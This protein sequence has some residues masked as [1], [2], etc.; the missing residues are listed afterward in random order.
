MLVVNGATHKSF[1]APKEQ[2][3]QLMSFSLIR[4]TALR[5]THR[6]TDM[7][8]LSLRSIMILVEKGR[9]DMR[10]QV[11]LGQVLTQ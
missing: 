6:A 10:M 7:R 8:L 4:L 2:M 9:S 5:G 3:Y 11:F 1:V